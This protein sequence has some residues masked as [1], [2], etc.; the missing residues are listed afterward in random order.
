MTPFWSRLWWNPFWWVGVEIF[1]GKIGPYGM[2]FV[3]RG[4]LVRDVTEVRRLSFLERADYGL[5]EWWHDAASRAHRLA[6]AL[7]LLRYDYT[8]GRWRLRWLR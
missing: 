5:G 1:S 2:T 8:Q 4:A 7:G 6:C 3:G